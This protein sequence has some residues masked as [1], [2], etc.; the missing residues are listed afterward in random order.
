VSKVAK[1]INAY[2][3]SSAQFKVNEKPMVSTFEGTNFVSQWSDVESST[4][5]LFLVPDWASMGPQTFATH[6]DVV[7]G[8]CEYMSYP[9]FAF[10][11]MC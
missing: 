2:K 3:D 10:S 7:D 5:Q 9:V 1:F 11:T 6:L 8:A 4:G